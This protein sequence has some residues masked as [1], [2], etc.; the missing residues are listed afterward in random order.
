MAWRIS[1]RV[2]DTRLVANLGFCRGELVSMDRPIDPNTDYFEIHRSGSQN[3]LAARAQLVTM[4][5][6]WDAYGYPSPGGV[7]V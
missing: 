2:S 5:T 1:R 4:D 3:Y 7:A 6:C